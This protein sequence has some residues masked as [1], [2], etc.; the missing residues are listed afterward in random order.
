MYVYRYEIKFIGLLTFSKRDTTHVSI[1]FFDGSQLVIWNLTRLQPD[2]GPVTIVHKNRSGSP[3]SFSLLCARYSA[4]V[5]YV[6]VTYPEQMIDDFQRFI[7]F[8]PA[9]YNKK[10]FLF[11]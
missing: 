5:Y 10:V 9:L 3:L 8:R 11:R 1:F 2:I 7:H 6:Q 4:L